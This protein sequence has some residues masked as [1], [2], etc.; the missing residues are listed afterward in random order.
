[1]RRAVRA[2]IGASAALAIALLVL[3]RTPAGIIA[4]FGSVA[5]LSGADFGG[6]VRRRTTALLWTAL[7][8]TLLVAVAV[9]ASRSTA[10]LVLVTFT[11]TAC[12]AFLV[13]LRGAFAS[14]CPSLTIVYVA[15]AMTASSVSEMGPM[16]AGW[17]IAV[18]VSL[19]VMLLVLPRRDLAPVRQA[20]V[21]GL[22]C[23]AEETRR[24]RDGEPVDGDAIRPVL[25]RLSG[26]YLGNP[27]RAAGLRAPDRAL[28]VLVGQSEGLLTALLRGDRFDHPISPLPGTAELIESS[29]QCLDHLADALEGRAAT[30]PSGRELAADWDKQWEHGVD[31]L[32]HEAGDSTEQRVLVVDQAFPDRAFALAVV[33]LTILVRRVLGLP[34]EPFDGIAHA[35]PEPP[36]AHPWR[37]LLAQFSLSSPWLRTA[38]RTGVGLALAVVLVEVMGLAHG[39]WVLLGVLSTL[40]MD[41]LATLK[42]S[43]LAVLGTF[44][45]AFLGYLVLEAVSLHYFVLWSMFAAVTFLAVYTQATT[46]YAVGQ[47]FFSLFVIIAFSLADWPPQLDVAGQRVVDI[48]VG[49]AVSVVVA[50]L[51]WPQGVLKGLRSNVVSAIDQASTLMSDAMKDLVLG[52]GHTRPEEVTESTATFVRSKEVVEV[53]LAQRTPEAVEQAHAWQEVISHLRTL[54]VSGHLLAVWA[55]GHP[56]I[57]TVVP[58]LQEPISADARAV[59]Q[60]WRVVSDAIDGRAHGDSP[61]LPPFL[62]AAT[63]ALTQADLTDPV[64]AD[65][66]LAA[67]WAHGWIRM[68]YNAAISARVPGEAEALTTR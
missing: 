68:S 22:R 34:D 18:L 24:R 38:L 40:R 48:L 64:V 26:S 21:A 53:T 3:P 15:A 14:A 19:P 7:F 62:E 6:S 55:E 9:L 35:I 8:G 11:V 65:R 54:S 59:E 67:I 49:A 20:C 1:M 29:A 10:S 56:P 66:S 46:A 12:L 41:G 57:A 50:L 60:A 61:P 5:L 39:F 2:A 36:R 37:E 30:E 47:A 13:A 45:G 58:G 16:L 32:A 44:A 23:L 17:M 43:M 27:F 4:A 42:T 51:L 52:P 31:Y 33:R 63:R 25:S 28:L